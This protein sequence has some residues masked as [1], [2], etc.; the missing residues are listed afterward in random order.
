MITGMLANLIG[1]D[2][3]IVIAVVVVVLLFGGSGFL[4]LLAGSATRPTSSRRAWRR[5]TRTRT[6]AT[7]RPPRATTRRPVQFNPT[8]PLL[9][10]SL[11][12]GVG[13][14]VASAG[15]LWGHQLAEYALAAALVVVGLH[16]GGRPAVVL[17]VAGALMGAFAFVSKGPLAAL[18]IIP[19]RLHVYLDLV[20]AAAICCLAAVVPSRS[21]DSPDH[22]QRSHSS[23]A[24]SDVAHDR[25][26][27]APA[28]G[29]A[30]NV[31]G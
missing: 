29:P 27:P 18:R 4:S 15:P 12:D 30:W 28:P 19:K 5:V 11:G 13:Q 16:L 23:A 2:S 22:P 10:S 9:D 26:R 17:A 3:L 31:P 20:L 7:R 21:P 1:P 14:V 24:R 25:D 6:R 8:E